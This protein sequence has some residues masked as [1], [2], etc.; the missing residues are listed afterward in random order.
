MSNN[1][2]FAVVLS[3]GQGVRLWPLSRAARPKQFLAVSANG[4]TLLQEAVRRAIQLTGS[5]DTV[6]VAT[7]SAQA[8]LVREQLQGLPPE[9]LLAEPVG[10]NTAPSLALATY[11]LRQR[12]PDA[13]MVILPVDHIFHDE[14]P[15]FEAMKTAI[16]IAAGS[17]M[18]IAVGVPADHPSTSYGYLHL[19]GAVE[20][21]PARQVNE[22]VEK[23]DRERAE[24]FC[25]SGEYLWNT[26]T[27]A[28][29]VPVFWQ[30]IESHL[31]QVAETLRTLRH[32][33]S[34]D[35]LDSMY[36]MFPS[37]SVDYAIL[38]KAP[39]VAAVCGTFE[40]IDIGSLDNLA[41]IWP[42]DSGGNAARGDLLAYRSHGN[43]VYTDD[44]LVSL[45]GVDGL[46]VVRAGEVVLVC[47]RERLAEVRELLSQ[48]REK[49]FER[50]S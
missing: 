21:L 49:G 35:S 14:A 17:D 48:M 37:I 16:S 44:G 41:E 9:N 25:A 34:P 27:Y 11:V 20:G 32:P 8:P 6:L 2:I 4:Q 36:G 46:A 30:A 1:H 29:R 33:V 47:P 43:L 5:I 31:P 28:W 10:R 3:G 12:Q 24:A 22:F 42:A 18:L 38:E 13:V 23:P 19:A 26:G 15:W 7:G 45:V 50:Y 39:N 40:R